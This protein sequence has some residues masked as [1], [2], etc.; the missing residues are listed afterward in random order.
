VIPSLGT[1]RIRDELGRGS[2]GEVYRALA[3]DGQSVA[4]KLLRAGGDEDRRRRR[5]QREV[6]A[7][8]RL[9]HP[10][11]LPVIDFGRAH[12]RPFL[13]MPY[14]EGA[15]LEER[16]RTGPLPVVQAVRLVITLADAVHHA[17]GEGVLHRDLKPANVLIGP[18]DAPLLTDFGLALELEGERTR[19]TATGSL[20]GTPGYWSPEQAVGDLERLG[21]A[22]DVYGLG[23]TLYALLTGQP[24][25]TGRSL[26]EV[27]AATAYG[28]VTPVRTLRPQVDHELERVIMRSLSA[29]P[30]DRYQ[31]PEDLALALECALAPRGRRSPLLLAIPGVVLAALAGGIALAASRRAERAQAPVEPPPAA[32]DGDPTPPVAPPP[33]PAPPPAD[34]ASPGDPQPSSPP[35]AEQVAALI[36]EGDECFASGDPGGALAAFTRLLELDPGSADALVGRGMALADLDR[37]GEGLEEIDRALAIDPEHLAGGMNRARVL[38]AAGDRVAAQAQYRRVIQRYP[39]YTIAYGQLAGSLVRTGDYLEA[40]ATCDA[41]LERAPDD[42]TTLYWRSRL[43][44]LHLNDPQGGLRD[45]ERL[46]SMGERRLAM[47]LKGWALLGLADPRS[48]LEVFHR[49]LADQP[50]DNLA[51]VGRADAHYALDQRRAA[52]ADYRRYLGQAPRGPHGDH[53]RKRVTELEAR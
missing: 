20:L 28:R 17:H 12:G 51:L 24:P 7:M 34:E 26:H 49:V 44:V 23:A 38:A 50:R 45:A 27:L 2:G 37:V 48:A 21:P 35:T 3:P 29:A 36:A 47:T 11:I 46:L 53:A 18:A 39:D 30:E 19:L 52:L 41:C 22:T 4:I 40:A 9:R 10:G 13:V 5:F 42:Q 6:D 43:R 31:T 16:L 25:V 33:P 8:L 1:Y 15:S 14:V 32:S